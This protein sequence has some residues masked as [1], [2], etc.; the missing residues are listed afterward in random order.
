MSEP[1]T[2][3]IHVKH[4]ACSLARF[5]A[6]SEQLFKRLQ[7][8]DRAHDMFRLLVS[9]RSIMEPSLGANSISKEPPLAA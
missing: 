7:H 5:D 9:R 8:L 1:Y 3:A 2:G 4:L 6:E